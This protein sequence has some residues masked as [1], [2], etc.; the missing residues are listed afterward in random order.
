MVDEARQNFAASTSSVPAV[1]T[2][3]PIAPVSRRSSYSRSGKTNRVPRKML[4]AH[5]IFID[6]FEPDA[7]ARNSSIL[8]MD[9]SAASMSPLPSPSYHNTTHFSINQTLPT[10]PSEAP[11]SILDAVPIT[12]SPARSGSVG[13]S[14][15]VAPPQTPTRRRRATVVTRS[16]ETGRN[17]KSLELDLSPSKRREKSRSHGDLLRPITPITKLEFELER[18]KFTWPPFRDRQLMKAQTVSQPTPPPRLST[19]VDKRLFI[20]SSP[21]LSR[22][23]ESMHEATPPRQKDELTASPLHVESYPPKTLPAKSSVGLDTPAR[24]QLEGV[25]D[26]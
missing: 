25:Y 24:R 23:E 16:P 21:V 20:A 2:A 11:S 5:Q 6:D 10:I 19:V 13:P 9:R 8:S 14:T 3:L 18:R 4:A 22:V 15:V 26:R 12:E 17:T 1:P 7:Y